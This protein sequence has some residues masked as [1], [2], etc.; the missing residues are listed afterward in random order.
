MNPVQKKE[1][2][3]LLL[4][5]PMFLLLAHFDSHT[6]WGDAYNLSSLGRSIPD[7]IRWMVWQY[8]G[9]IGGTTLFIALVGLIMNNHG[10]SLTFTMIHMLYSIILLVF[11]ITSPFSRFMFTLRFFGIVIYFLASFFLCR[12]HILFE[13]GKMYSSLCFFF[14]IVSVIISLLLI[15]HN[16]IRFTGFRNLERNGL[17]ATIRNCRWPFSHAILLFM[18]S[19]GFKA[20]SLNE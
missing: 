9:F 12:Y 10:L 3:K 5:F 7:N 16:G 2:Q 4:L 18:M 19:S 15:M 6:L 20:I 1:W 13:K 8:M 17:L 14:V 11:A